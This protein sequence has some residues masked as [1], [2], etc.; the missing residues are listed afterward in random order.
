M[1]PDEDEQALLRAARD[2]AGAFAAFYRHFERPVLG[3]FMRATGRPEL[4]GDLAAETFAR[5]LESVDAFDPERGRADQWLFG[6][7]RHVLHDSHRRGRVEAAA[8]GRLGLPALVIDDEA[9]EAIARLAGE[10]CATLALA[11]L[12]SEQREAI[13]A[14][15]LNEREYPEIATELRCSEAVVRQRVSRG[16]RTL[17]ARLAGERP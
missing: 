9:A 14:R 12:P 15:V 3:F 7:A 16:L 11:E 6:V 2:D 8:R 17:R 5:V 4:A 10:E 13:A 1:N